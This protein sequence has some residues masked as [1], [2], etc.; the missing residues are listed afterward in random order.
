MTQHWLSEEFKHRRRQETH[1]V[2]FWS[3]NTACDEGAA[4]M[5]VV[6]VKRGEYT[7]RVELPWPEGRSK[8][9][10]LE[11]MFQSVFE[12]GRQDAKREIRDVL[13]LSRSP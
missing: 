8:L 12:K 6:E 1:E 5:A 13:G 11:Q 7:S 10:S 4:T 3:N 9:A 2:S